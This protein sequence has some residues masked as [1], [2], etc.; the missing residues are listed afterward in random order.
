MDQTYTTAI[1]E[2]GVSL[3]T[4]AVSGTATAIN[5]K[6]KAIKSEKDAE[7]YGMRTMKLSTN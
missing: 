6:I 4:M 5:T 7:K 1:A 3:A 2:L